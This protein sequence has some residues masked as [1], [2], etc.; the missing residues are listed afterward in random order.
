MTLFQSCYHNR[1]RKEWQAPRCMERLETYL[2]LSSWCAYSSPQYCMGLTSCS[3]EMNYQNFICLMCCYEQIASILCIVSTLQNVTD[4]IGES[5]YALTRTW[6]SLWGPVNFQ[7][8]VVNLRSASSNHSNRL[9]FV[10]CKWVVGT[11]VAVSSVT[12]VFAK[13]QQQPSSG[14]AVL[15]FDFVEDE[16]DFTW[17]FR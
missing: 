13:S 3:L 8:H 17:G 15:G 1:Q 5:L 11:S 4:A 9:Y 14:S 10:C 7:W 2:Q 6:G 12:F 16:C